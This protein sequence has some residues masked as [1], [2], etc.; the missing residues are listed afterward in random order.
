MADSGVRVVLVSGPD[1]ATLEVLGR[2]LVAERLAAC[3]NVIPGVTSV[4]R[5]EGDVQVDAEALAVI[6]TTEEA[7]EAAQRRVAE[8]H[9]Y[10]VPEFVALEVT[11]GLP[12]YV[13][14]VRES[15]EDATANG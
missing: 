4:Y 9:P 8:L 6:K 2:A 14:W 11:G 3:V 15:V 12:S 1:A 7:V 10:D 5:W 13:R